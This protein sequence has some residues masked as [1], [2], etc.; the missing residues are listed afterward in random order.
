MGKK[1][2]IIN[3]ISIMFVVTENIDI[4]ML[5]LKSQNK[6]YPKRCKCIFKLS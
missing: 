2:D 3:A 5:V 1:D 6:K 4:K